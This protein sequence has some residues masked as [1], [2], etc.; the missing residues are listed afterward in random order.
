M[1]IV[2]KSSPESSV[3]DFF[4]KQEE[5][6]SFVG[7]IITIE[8]SD[9]TKVRISEISLPGLITKSYNI[10]I[11]GGIRFT[12]KGD[13]SVKFIPMI[14]FFDITSKDY[15]IRDIDNLNAV[16]EKDVVIELPKNKEKSIYSIRFDNVVSPHFLLNENPLQDCSNEKTGCP[17]LLYQSF[18]FGNYKVKLENL[19]NRLYVVDVF[20]NQAKNPCFATFSIECEDDIKYVTL[21]DK[22]FCDEGLNSACSANFNLCGGAVSIDLIGKGDQGT[23]CASNIAHKVVINAV[24]G[25]KWEPKDFV[26]LSIWNVRKEPNSDKSCVESR[27]DRFLQ[28]CT[29]DFLASI[30]MPVC[31][32]NGKNM[33]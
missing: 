31:E 3:K 29:K 23:D 15:S 14:T 18:K 26:T 4:Q 30:T 10:E 1:L 28:E 13:E 5:V 22:H 16:Y 25:K 24:D 7:D 11:T 32:V 33:C 6:K 27:E 20:F 19:H 2:F 9:A 17:M 8:T 21:I 12:Y